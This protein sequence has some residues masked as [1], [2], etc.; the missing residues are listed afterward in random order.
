[1]KPIA[2]L[3]HSPEAPAGYLGDAIRRTGLASFV[4]RLH[5]GEA[6]PDLAEISAVVSL[7]G[8]MGAYEEDRYP[9][10]AAEKELLRQAVAMGLPV[11]GICLGCHML[12]D[13]LGGRAYPADGIEAEFVGL[14]LTPEAEADP[15]LRTLAEPVVSLHGDTWD[16]PPGAAVPVRSGRFPHAFRYGSAVAIQSHPEVSAAIVAEWI[17]GFGRDRFI[18]AGVNPDEFLG[19]ITDGDGANKE[20]AGRLFGAWL[21]EVVAT[22]RSNKVEPR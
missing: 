10:L 19:Q 22:Q 5:A 9:F 8:S 4:A 14:Q 2:I 11:L 7:G 15:I 18:A 17:D 21:D 20:R 13:A 16:P 3:E 1:M 12:A 6:L